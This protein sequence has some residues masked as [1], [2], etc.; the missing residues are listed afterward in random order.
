MARTG[1]NRESHDSRAPK[2]ELAM[3]LGAACGEA[4]K[5]PLSAPRRTFVVVDRRSGGESGVKGEKGLSDVRRWLRV[6]IMA[7]G[8]RGVASA[9]WTSCSEKGVPFPVL[10]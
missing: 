5:R 6:I 7:L 10:A 4:W 3:I 2:R 9:F 8:G 1:Q